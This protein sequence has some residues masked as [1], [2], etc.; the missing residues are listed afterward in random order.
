MC[1]VWLATV[2]LGRV[3]KTTPLHARSE[4]CDRES[5]S[6]FLQLLSPFLVLLRDTQRTAD[7]LAFSSCAS[8]TS[9]SRSIPTICSVVYRFRAIPSSPQRSAEIAGSLNQLGPV[10]GEQVSTSTT[11]W[12]RILAPP[13]LLPLRLS[14]EPVVCSRETSGT[15][16]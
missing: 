5:I 3:G 2:A 9:S 4:L 7:S 14:P 10:S 6:Q 11:W 12:W 13:R 15:D 16:P 8:H 1:F